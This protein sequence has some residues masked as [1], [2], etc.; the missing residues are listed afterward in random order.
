MHPTVFVRSCS[1]R[2][3]L[4]YAPLARTYDADWRKL[5][6]IVRTS[7][8]FESVEALNACFK[9]IAEDP[10]V[11]VLYGKEEKNRLRDGYDARSSLG[12]RDVQLNVKLV[13]NAARLSNVEQFVCELQLHM[14]PMHKKKSEFEVSRKLPPRD[15][16]VNAKIEREAAGRHGRIPCC[17]IH[18][19][20]GKNKNDAEC[21]HDIYI[22]Y[23]NA[24]AE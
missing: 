8:V 12:Y 22:Q 6:D 2:T 18:G 24:W 19:L 15:S 23:R 3:S 1:R 16:D 10:D 4:I 9:L 14:S 7:I 17:D 20:V 13:S 11:E 21:G 5:C